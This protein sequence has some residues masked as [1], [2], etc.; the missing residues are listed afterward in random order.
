M[1]EAIVE[2]DVVVVGG[3]PAGLSAA[4]A[5]KRL[6]VARVILLERDS[7]VGGIPRHCGHSPF[8]M[9]EFQ[10]I[11]SGTRYVA[12]LEAEAKEAGVDIRT[13]HSVLSV[14]EGE[15]SAISPDGRLRVQASRIV[16]ATGARETPRSARLVSGERPLGVLNTAALQAYVHLQKLVPFKQ[17]V[18]VGTELVAMSALLT[19]RSAGIRPVAVV[20]P[21]DR[22]TARFPVTLLPRLLGV[23]LHYG[24]TIDGIGGK[25]RVSDVTIR[26]GTQTR[27]IACDGVLFTGAFTPES[28]LARM[29]GLAIDDA[30]GGPVVDAFGRTSSASV[31]AAGNLLRPVET[32][33]WCW[34]EGKRIAASVFADIRQGLPDRER[35]IRIRAGEGIKLVMPQEISRG[36]MRLALPDLQVRLSTKLQGTLRLS[37]KHNTIWSRAIDSAPERR[38]LIPI[39][40]IALPDEATDLTL[41]VDSQ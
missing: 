21:N 18:I 2:A 40:G 30:S 3:G 35:T 27:T 38:I 32:A 25:G 39:A 4:T 34:A 15:V 16:L 31:F 29:S 11:L 24:T 5:L 37:L 23:P 8:G 22:P 9:R 7:V 19:C 28:A 36:T 10:R 17:P 1:V 20:E 13:R 12:R 6:G 33:G 41:S 14:S 26:S